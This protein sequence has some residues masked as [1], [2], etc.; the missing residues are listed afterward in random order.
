MTTATHNGNGSQTATENNHKFQ[1]KWRGDEPLP[2]EADSR[3]LIISLLGPDF[4]PTSPRNLPAQDSYKMKRVHAEQMA[5]MLNRELLEDSMRSTNWFVVAYQNDGFRVLQ[6][7]VPHN[8]KPVDE[9]DTPP[10]ASD[11]KTNATSRRDLLA[12]NRLQMTHWKAGHRIEQWAV[13]IKPLR[14]SPVA[15]DGKLFHEELTEVEASILETVSKA[16]KFIDAGKVIGE[17]SIKLKCPVVR[18]LGGFSWQT[19]KIIRED[20]SG[21]LRNIATRLNDAANEIDG[22]TRPPLVLA[23]P[24]TQEVAIE[25][26]EDVSLLVYNCQD[27]EELILSKARQALSAMNG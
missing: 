23:K 26:F 11:A 24:L 14:R 25:G 10:D 21:Q 2:A 8:W 22:E 6:V 1:H 20:A 17:F 3:I 4:K 5:V 12:F 18:I 15:I 13:H 9:Y 19:E 7:S 16:T 27:D